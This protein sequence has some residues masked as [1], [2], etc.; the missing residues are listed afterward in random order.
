MPRTVIERVDLGR[1]RD[2]KLVFAKRDDL[3]HATTWEIA[4]HRDRVV[5]AIER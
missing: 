3:A 1:N 4:L 2:G 5:I